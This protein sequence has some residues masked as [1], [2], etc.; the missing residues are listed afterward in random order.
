MVH[1][2]ASSVQ[3]MLAMLRDLSALA[4]FSLLADAAHVCGMLVVLKD[5]VQ[6]FR[7]AHEAVA[8]SKGWGAVPVLFGV[9][10]YCY[11]GI[12]MILQ[13][14]DSMK[15]RSKVRSPPGPLRC[16]CRAPACDLV[17]LSA[18]KAACSSCPHSFGVRCGCA[19][20]TWHKPCSSARR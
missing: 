13:I 7:A 2:A 1:I 3:A 9:V 12:G 15:D 20:L 11:E 18:D 16:T 17:P 6:H 5:D 8:A 10:I 4:P 19:R 14:E